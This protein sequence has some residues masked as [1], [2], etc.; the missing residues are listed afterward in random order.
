M[1]DWLYYIYVKARRESQIVLEN[2]KLGLVSIVTS[3][4]R[5]FFLCRVVLENAKRN[6]KL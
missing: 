4:L 2:M 1:P 5:F 3:G 6:V